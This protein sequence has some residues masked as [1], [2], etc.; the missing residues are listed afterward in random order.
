MEPERG[1][2]YA[3]PILR[4]AELLRNYHAILDIKKIKSQTIKLNKE[5]FKLSETISSVVQDINSG[6]IRIN[7]RKKMN[8]RLVIKEK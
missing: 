6:P 2:E 3:T 8:V 7:Q 5:K 4:N 1:K